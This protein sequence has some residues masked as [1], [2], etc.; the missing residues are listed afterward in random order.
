[1]WAFVEI[2]NTKQITGGMWRKTE[3]NSKQ[4]W[5]NSHM[6]LN[7]M[8]GI[9]KD[10]CFVFSLQTLL[11]RSFSY[12][13]IMAKVQFC[14]QNSYWEHWYAS[15]NK[16]WEIVHDPLNLYFSLSLSLSHTHTHTHTHRG[17]AAGAGGVLGYLILLWS[18][19]QVTTHVPHRLHP[20][21]NPIGPPAAVGTAPITETVVLLHS[22]PLGK[23]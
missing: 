14:F 15:V 8:P 4:C 6:V 16:C 13:M 10:Y 23:R 18:K 3:R 22:G 5:H 1:M 20:C 2:W 17:L 7:L 19:A 11:Y 21:C 9:C 12:Y